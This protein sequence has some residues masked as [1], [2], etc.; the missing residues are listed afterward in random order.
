MTYREPDEQAGRQRREL[1]AE[2]RRQIA[3]FQADLRR[4]STQRRKV[5]QWGFLA[6]G[7]LAAAVVGFFFWLIAHMG[8]PGRPIRIRGVRLPSRLCTRARASGVGVQ[9]RRLPL[10][11]V[12]ERSRRRLARLW[13]SDARAEHASITAF[14]HLAADLEAAG[15][16]A[17]LVAFARR[18]AI[19]EVRHAQVCLAIASTYA[20]RSLRLSTAPFVLARR[21]RPEPRKQLVRRLAVESLLD[22]VIG[23]GASA[24]TAR[25]GAREATDPVVRILLMRVAEEEEG[26]AKLARKIVAW[27]VGEEPDVLQA[28]RAALQ[29]SKGGRASGD[30]EDLVESGRV[31]TAA[32]T[33]LFHEAHEEARRFVATLADRS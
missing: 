10:R 12:G 15:A 17:D 20:G 21:D 3:A 2:D 6:F 30:P 7:F 24:R 26:H 28:L 5:V 9:T 23:E 13:L 25:R 19:E 4:P 1:E 11:P 32:K 16:D 27:G 31:G 29:R 14:E 18:A 8:A 33:T 22:G